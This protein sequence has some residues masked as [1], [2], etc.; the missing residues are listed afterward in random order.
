[1]AQ[2]SK[3]EW[4]ESTW[5]PV[6]GCTKI[7]AGCRNC[8]AE[9]MALRLK[10]A[11]S[12]NY[13]S[14]F[15]VTLHPHAL[16]IPLHWKQPRT[17]FVNSMSDLFHKAVP[18]DFISKIFDVMSQASH[19]RFQVLTKRSYRLQQLSPCLD[20]PQNVW[21]GVTVENADCLFRIDHL[22][23]TPAEIK[24]VSFEPLLGPIPD[25]NLEGIDWV[26]VGGESGPYARPMEHD[27]VI[28]IRDQC[29]AA[30][31]PFFFKQWGGV[32]KKRN[33][34]LLNGQTWSNMPIPIELNLRRYVNVGQ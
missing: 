28:D 33:G 22:R 27:W 12:P 32:N 23:Q 14:G 4:T 3:I 11:S 13:A 15:R 10:A 1:M 30:N 2:I 25:I 8:Y 26:I 18:L 24:F 6:T 5:N 20:W 19:H 16:K 29:L 9:R 31:I 17:I 34:R 7:S 21:M